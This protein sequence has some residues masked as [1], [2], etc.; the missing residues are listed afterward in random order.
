MPPLWKLYDWADLE[1][2][3]IYHLSCYFFAVGPKNTK[4]PTN[5]MSSLVSEADFGAGC[6]ICRAGAVPG[7]P[8]ARR[9]PQGAEN[10]AKTRGRIYGFI[11][12]SQ[13][14]EFVA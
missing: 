6:T 4:M 7:A 11:P 13:E 5:G 8:G 9:G 10:L 3:R 12:K 1:G 2:L 14:N